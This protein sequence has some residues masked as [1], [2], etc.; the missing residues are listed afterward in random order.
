MKCKASSQK[1]QRIMPRKKVF[2]SA[3]KLD[4]EGRF[5]T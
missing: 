4:T 1:A 2:K 5:G 3:A